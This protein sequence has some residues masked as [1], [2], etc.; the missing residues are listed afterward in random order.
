MRTHILLYWIHTRLPVE[1]ALRLD[2]EA[3]PT[4]VPRDFRAS[5]ELS[6]GR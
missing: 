4:S 1:E 6:T 5:D 2:E 3:M